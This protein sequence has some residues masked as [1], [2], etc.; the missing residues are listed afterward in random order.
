MVTFMHALYLNKEMHNHVL[1]L[2]GIQR[3]A[4][5][6]SRVYAARNHVAMPASDGDPLGRMHALNARN[7]I[8]FVYIVVHV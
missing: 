2:T 6:L 5:Y 7:N 8:L 4:Q 3:K 1:N